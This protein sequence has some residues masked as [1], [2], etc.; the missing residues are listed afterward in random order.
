[1][2]SLVAIFILLI[3][4]T[5]FAQS[6]QGVKLS[7][8]EIAK[9]CAELPKEKREKIKA[10]VRK[11]SKEGFTYLTAGDPYLGYYKE[12]SSWV[13][14]GQGLGGGDISGYDV[15]VGYNFSQIE[16]GLFTSKLKSKE[17][18]E[19]GQFDLDAAGGYFTYNYFPVAVQKK[20][21]I[22]INM[23]L[24]LGTSSLLLQSNGSKNS[25]P[26]I[27]LG[28]GAVIPVVSN[29]SFTLG[30]DLHQIIHT[31]KN[32]FHLGSSLGAGLRF[33]F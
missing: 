13:L 10:C 23:T 29:V 25:Y 14:R 9:K 20:G 4:S 19:V 22:N 12:Q 31:E 15:L 6:K 17:N 28:A 21:Q 3:T 26:Y 32:L 16:V 2:K 18:S 27:G 30:L 8:K 1:M 24:K 11:T 33:D 7:A 5:S